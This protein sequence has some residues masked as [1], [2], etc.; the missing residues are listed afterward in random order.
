M[1]CLVE[2]IFGFIENTMNGPE[3]EYIGLERIKT[4]IGLANLTYNLSRFVQLVRLNR[5]PATI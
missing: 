1:R 3:L 4:G 2:H 5:V